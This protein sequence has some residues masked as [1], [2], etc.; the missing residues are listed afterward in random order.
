[1]ILHGHETWFHFRE[2]T[3]LIK[4]RRSARTITGYKVNKINKMTIPTTCISL[5]S[6][7]H[8]PIYWS[9]QD[10]FM[11]T[12]MVVKLQFIISRWKHAV[13]RVSIKFILSSY[14][15]T[16]INFI[17]NHHHHWQDSPFGPITFL[18]NFCQNTSGFHFSWFR[19]NNIFYRA[20]SSAL[21]PASNLENQVL[22]FMSPS[23]RVAQLYHRSPCSIFVAFYDSQGYG[24]GVR[25]RLHTAI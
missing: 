11:S 19:N 6:P 23:D 2:I 7:Q 1:M 3:N 10:D 17:P 20:R 25:T 13:V 5:L 24:G 8:V 18:R 14:C 15:I 9:S 4:V 21:R 12:C 16:I 22:V